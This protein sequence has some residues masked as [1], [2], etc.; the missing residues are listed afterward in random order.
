MALPL[1]KNNGSLTLVAIGADFPVSV[2]V[3]TAVQ[4][5]FIETGATRIWVIITSTILGLSGTQIIMLK[6]LIANCFASC[7][8]IVM[9]AA[10][11]VQ[12][13]IHHK[14][15]KTEKKKVFI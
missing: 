14:I 15:N 2:P 10:H 13:N 11:A 12:Y 8:D 3:R 4:F 1:S 6:A 9:I 5:L 7:R